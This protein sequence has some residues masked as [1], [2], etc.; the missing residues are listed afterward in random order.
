MQILRLPPYPLTISY[1]VP[2]PNTD[3]ILVI[4][5]GTRDVNDVTENIVSTAGAKLEYTL[6]D[7]F[8]SYDESYYLAIYEDIEGL[9]GDIVVEDN[10][11]ITRPYSDPTKLAI[12]NGATLGRAYFC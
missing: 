9:P 4:N 2:L 3:Y 8:N 11:D 7:L 1:D 6:P 5:Q 12:K 10:L